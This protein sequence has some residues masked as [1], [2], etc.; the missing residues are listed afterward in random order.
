MTRSVF[1]LV[2]LVLLLFVA[3]TP[4]QAEG[5]KSVASSASEIRPLLPGME[6]PDVTFF[7]TDGSPFKLKEALA[8]KPVVLIFYRGGW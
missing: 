2:W 3:A 7:N 1:T 8:Q 5:E 6:V 4:I